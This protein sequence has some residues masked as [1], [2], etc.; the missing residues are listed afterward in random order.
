MQRRGGGAAQGAGGLTACPEGAEHQTSTA[1][2]EAVA[3]NLRGFRTLFIGGD[4]FGTDD[5]LDA[6]RHVNLTAEILLRTD[7]AI[8]IAD[9]TT[10]S[11][12]DGVL[13]NSAEINALYDAVQ[14]VTTLLKTDL[15][16]VLSIEVP[17]ELSGDN[18]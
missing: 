2:V 18:D 17:A 8:E 7:T 4:G 6:V 9:T 16:T 11:I 15:V 12:Q 14:D 3:A 13:E 1:S 5:L 10:V